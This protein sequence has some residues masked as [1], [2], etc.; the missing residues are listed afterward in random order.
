MSSQIWYGDLVRI[1]SASETD[2]D[3]ERM[4]NAAG[5]EKKDIEEDDAH[6]PS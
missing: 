3:F 1:L 5:F 6:D 2:E 4:A